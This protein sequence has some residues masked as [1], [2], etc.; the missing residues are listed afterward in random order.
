MKEG[1]FM[2]DKILQKFAE[3][4]GAEGDVKA[5]FAPGRVNLIGEH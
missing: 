3:V 4:F 2:K 5:Y 1:I